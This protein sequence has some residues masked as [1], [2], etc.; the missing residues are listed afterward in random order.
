MAKK[1][2]TVWTWAQ[3]ND[4]AKPT[5]PEKNRITT[6]FATF[7]QALNAS[8]PA[9][10]E[11]QEFNQVVKIE[12][13]WRGSYFYLMSHYK[14]APRPNNIKD[15]FEMGIARLTAKGGNKYDLAYF[16]HTGKWFTLLVDLSA[17]ECLEYIKTQPIFTV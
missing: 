12:S 11:P 1:S 2:K 16:R 4:P 15:G 9:L 3:S 17:E 14:S 5:E 7:V 8:L 13:K 10:A 6:L